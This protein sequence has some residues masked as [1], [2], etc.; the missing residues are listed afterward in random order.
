MKQRQQNE[1]SPSTSENAGRKLCSINRQKLVYFTR[2]AKYTKKKQKHKQISLAATQA[3]KYLNE[4]DIDRDYFHNNMR[5][6]QILWQTASQMKSGFDVTAKV[7]NFA[8]NITSQIR[9]S[10]TGGPILCTRPTLTSQFAHSVK[11]TEGQE[12][13]KY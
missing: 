9:V 1:N 11:K 3:T 6:L 12:Q 10:V 13:R 7:A 8:T 2:K 5:F 4:H